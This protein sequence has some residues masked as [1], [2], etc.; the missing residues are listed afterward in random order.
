MIVTLPTLA[1]GTGPDGNPHETPRKLTMSLLKISA[2]AVA[3]LLV[4]QAAL[5]QSRNAIIPTYDAVR[6]FSLASNPHGVWSYGWLDKLGGAFTLYTWADKDTCWTGLSTWGMPDCVEPKVTHN[7]TG[8]LICP[9]TACFPPGYLVLHP[10]SSGQLSVVRWTVPSPG[11]FMIQGKVA[12]TDV[13]GTTTD[14]H[15]VQNTTKELF[16]ANI[17]GYGSPISFHRVLTVSAG[18][19]L[20]FVVGFGSDGAYDFDSTGIQFKIFQMQ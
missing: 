2:L 9:G 20:D 12:G 19:T 1:V 14:F 13:F 5:A 10:G 11:T 6:D 8:A 15:V 3:L 16:R 4:P 17:D 18:D 7:D